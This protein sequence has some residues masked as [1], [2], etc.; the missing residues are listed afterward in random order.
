MEEGR[1]IQKECARF[2]DLTSLPKCKQKVDVPGSAKLVLAV[3]LSLGKSKLIENKV[4]N[5]GACGR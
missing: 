1:I 5:S 2:I 3:C 4:S